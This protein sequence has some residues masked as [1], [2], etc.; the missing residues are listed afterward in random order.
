MVDL[1]K[2]ASQAETVRWFNGSDLLS[3]LSAQDFLRRLNAMPEG[4]EVVIMA[5]SS[6]SKRAFPVDTSY[7]HASCA[8]RLVL[9]T[10]FL[11]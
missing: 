8:E 7:D 9:N 4:C 10:S 11:Y 5:K 3:E 2:A 1:K 6:R